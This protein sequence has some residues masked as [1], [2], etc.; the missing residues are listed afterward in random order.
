MTF[1]GIGALGWTAIVGAAGAA[2]SVAQGQ[3][4]RRQGKQGLRQQQ[5]A[6]KTTEDA[7]TR[8]RQDAAL[9]SSRAARQQEQLNYNEVLA[10]EDELSRLSSGKGS[11]ITGA[12]P[13]SPDRAPSTLGG[14]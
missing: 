1:L 3:Q 5:S 2:A 13:P 6:Q 12:K 14:Y 10:G 7:M 9:A 4:A 8:Q 11:T